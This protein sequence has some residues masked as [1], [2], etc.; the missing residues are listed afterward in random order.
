GDYA[1][2][3][4]IFAGL[5]ARYPTRDAGLAGGFRLGLARYMLGDSDAALRS[6]SDVLA[7]DP[8]PNVRAQTLYWTGKAVP[9]K[10]DHAA[11]QNAYQS[12]AGVRPV[13]F[14]VMRA[15]V[16][17]DP[18]P[19]SKTFDLSSASPADE[20]ELARWFAGH[21]LDLKVAARTASQDPAFLRASA[22]VQHGL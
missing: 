14:Y 22:L 5:V 18:P 2:A 1:S 13:D 8:Q 9:R 3:A 21:G 19:A 10:G 6:W 4:R 11:A 16:P 7:R 17:L 12:A 15:Q 20:A